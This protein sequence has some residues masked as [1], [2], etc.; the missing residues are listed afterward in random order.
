MKLLLI[1]ILLLFTAPVSAQRFTGLVMGD[2]T[3][4]PLAYAKITSGS[5]VAISGPDGVFTLT[6]IRVTDSIRVSSMGYLPYAFK[7]ASINRKDTVVVYLQPTGYALKQVNI[8]GKRDAKADSARL[9]KEFSSAFNYKAPTL[10]D[11]LIN[12]H[13]EIQKYNDFITSYNNTS[14]IVGVDVLSVIGLLSKKKENKSRLQK[15]LIKEEAAN[16]IDQAFS[17]QKVMDI[18]G[19]KGDSLQTFMDKYRP[20][21]AQLR[22][23]SD[24]QLFSY[25]K[26]KHAEFIGKVKD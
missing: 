20:T 11:A 12:K 8:K 7:P 24:Y 23:M 25:I 3:R 21:I 14:A 16:Y 5:V 19:L 17:R 18:T 26:K 13:Y 10:T 6:G 22:K 2:V 9:R 15:I 1:C 4:T